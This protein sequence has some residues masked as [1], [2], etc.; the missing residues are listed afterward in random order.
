[1]SSA[2]GFGPW[3]VTEQGALRWPRRV[4][5]LLD[6]HPV[7]LVAVV[8]SAFVVFQWWWIANARFFGALDVDEASSVATS[9]GFHRALATGP[10]ELVR[11][12]LG[13]GHGPLVPLLSIPFVVVFGRSAVSPMFVQPF[14]VMLSAIGAAGAVN[15]LVGRRAAVVAG[16]CTLAMPA[17][18]ISSRTD[19]F[20]NGVGAAMCLAIW[21][22]LASDRARKPWPV[23][24]FGVACGAMTISR[25]M[26]V[27]F[28][29]AMIAAVVVVSA[30]RERRVWRNLAL[31]AVGG[32]AVAVPWWWAQW[33]YVSS[34]LLSSGYG[35]RSSF[36]GAE[37]IAGRVEDHVGYLLRDFRAL[38]PTGVFVIVVAGIEGARRARGGLGAWFARNRDVLAVWAA[39]A[40]GTLAL[41]SSSNRGLLFA[42]PLDS[43]LVIAAVASG[44][45]LLRSAQSISI[46]SVAAGIAVSVRMTLKGSTYTGV[47]VEWGLVVMAAVALIVAVVRS[48]RTVAVGAVVLGVSTAVI[49][50]SVPLVGPST[51]VADES[52]RGQ[53]V[54]GIEPL[55]PT[56]F[57][58]D[59]R[60]LSPD[61]DTRR[62]VA[63]E[64]SAAAQELDSL[65]NEYEEEMSLADSDTLAELVTG[66][67]GLFSGRTIAIARE[68]GPRGVQWMEEPNTFETS[69]EQILEWLT[70][71]A[72]DGT[73]RIIIAIEG[74]ASPFPDSLGWHRLVRLAAREGWV[75]H[76]EIPLPDRGRVAIYVH[77]SNPAGDDTQS[78]SAAHGSA[79]SQNDD[80]GSP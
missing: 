76:S 8:A 61:L 48:R 4:V 58:A 78:G 71:T 41:L 63:A 34:Y 28:M 31:G 14:L 5:R 1:M 16:C 77:P 52:L 18:V 60:L 56:A 7:V 65:L 49:A 30:V 24:A 42:T 38:M 73:P 21:A 3:P 45:R 57:E 10:V 55:L 6:D 68:L 33:D 15:Q 50:A 12:A 53:L 70:P 51:S 69:D 54:G 11:E 22:L 32:L 44:T 29:P 75:L 79:P 64:W 27:S 20:S 13:T 2:L 46:W 62:R 40:G 80:S 74:R 43:L 26:S 37:S 36:Y 19:Q 67:R 23:L 9:L 72:A 17:L 47:G 66:A 39:I 35:G 59:A 25:T